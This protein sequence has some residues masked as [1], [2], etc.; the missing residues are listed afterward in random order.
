MSWL[1]DIDI[2]TTMLTGGHEVPPISMSSTANRGRASVAG[3]QRMASS[4]ARGTSSG[5]CA[6]QRPLVGVLGESVDHV[7]ELVARRVGAGHEHHRHHR[8]QFRCDEP[9][10]FLLGGDEVREQVVA[11]VAHGA[12]R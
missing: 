3:S 1:A 7:A 12:G 6:Q 4:T 8:Q 9:V 10:A 11:R 5:R 2:S